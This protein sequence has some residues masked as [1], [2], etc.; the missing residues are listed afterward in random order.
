MDQRFFD[1]EMAHIFQ[2]S[3]LLAAHIDELP[4]P[5]C[6]RLWDNAGTP[7]IITHTEA[8]EIKAF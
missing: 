5:G 4:E 7:V 8:G 6:Y 3:W 2:K 1:L